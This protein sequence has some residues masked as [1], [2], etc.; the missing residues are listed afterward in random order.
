MF[1]KKALENYDKIIEYKINKFNLIKI[2]EDEKSEMCKIEISEYK[3]KLYKNQN[4]KEKIE[5]EKDN[6]INIINEKKSLLNINDFIINSLIRKNQTFFEMQKKFY[7][8]NYLSIPIL[9]GL[10]DYSNF[11]INN[12]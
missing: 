10:I 11:L 5:L 12:C 6:L 4:L 1:L 7:L 9:E 2:Q 3:K 8:N